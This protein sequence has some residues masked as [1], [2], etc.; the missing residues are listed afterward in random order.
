VKKIF[1]PIVNHIVMLVKSQVHAVQRKGMNVKV[2]VYNHPRYLVH[3]LTAQAIILVG[4]FG[5]SEYLRKR[6]E[7]ARYGGRELQVLQPI[8]A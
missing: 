6:L 8:N 3:G 1:D 4:G 2:C 7:E 5:S